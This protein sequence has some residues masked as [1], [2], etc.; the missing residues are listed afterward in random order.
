LHQEQGVKQLRGRRLDARYD[1]ICVSSNGKYRDTVAMSALLDA[2]TERSLS[3]ARGSNPLSGLPGNEVIR[4]EIE[5]RIAQLMHFDVCY[6]DIDNFK[7]FNDTYGFHSGDMAL[8][9]VSTAITE[10][11]QELGDAGDFAGHIGG[12]DLLLITQPALSIE[13]CRRIV[14]RFARTPRGSRP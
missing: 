7:P 2:M 3:L 12:D 4:R 14:K 1:D 13:L 6:I 10:A 11:V 9:H 5:M 8:R